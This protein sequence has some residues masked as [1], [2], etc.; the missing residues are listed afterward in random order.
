[1]M[2][3]NKTQLAKDG[4]QNRSK[5]KWGCK[6]A[7][8][9]KDRGKSTIKLFFLTDAKLTIIINKSM[10]NKIMIKKKK[11]MVT[12]PRTDRPS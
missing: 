10:F 4:V 8:L 12:S 1:M 3:L 11:D 5:K 9:A 7:Q 6:F 2:I